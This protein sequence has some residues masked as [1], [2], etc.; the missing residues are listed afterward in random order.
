MKWCQADLKKKKQTLKWKEL[1]LILKVQ[2]KQNSA[3]KKESPQK[4]VK[5]G[6]VYE[7]RP[8]GAFHVWVQIYMRVKRS[9]I[10]LPAAIR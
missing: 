5:S 6:M 8:I 3:K 1:N 9:Y 2:W 7:V 10:F 4:S